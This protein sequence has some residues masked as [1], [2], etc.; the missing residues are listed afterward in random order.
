MVPGVRSYPFQHGPFFADFLAVFFA[1][2]FLVIAM[3]A[4]AVRSV[5]SDVRIMDGRRERGAKAN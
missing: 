4:S 3:I 1:A 2:F 5:P